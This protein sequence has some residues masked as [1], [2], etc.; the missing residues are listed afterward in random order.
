VRGSCSG[1][2]EDFCGEIGRFMQ[3]QPRFCVRP[4]VSCGCSGTAS[5]VEEIMIDVV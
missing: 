3:V 1:R 4:S 2:A 5:F